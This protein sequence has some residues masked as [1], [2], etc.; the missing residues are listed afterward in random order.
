MEPYTLNRSFLRNNVIDKFK[1]IIWT[2]RYYGDSAVEM[3]VP[4]TTDMFQKLA[5]GTFLAID[6][7]DEVMILE[8]MS[9]EKGELKVSGISILPWLDNRFVRTSANHEDQH[10]P[11]EFATAGGAVAAIIWYM[12]CDG[13]PYLDGTL[14]M[15]ISNPQQFK[16]PGLV[17]IQD[18]KSGGPVKLAIPYGPV[19]KAAREVATT[20][21][22]G[23][24]ITL[25]RADDQGYLLGLRTYKGLDRTSNQDINPVVRFS[26]QM[27]SFTDIKELQSIAALKTVVYTFATGLKPNEGE[28][29]IT[30]T[31]GVATLSGQYTGFDL[32]A[33]QVFPGDITTDLVGGDPAKVVDILNS[34]ALDELTGHHFI[35]SVDGEIVPDSQFKYGAHYNLGDLIEV[36][37]NTGVTQAARITEYI[38]SHDSAGEK[39]YPTVTMIG[40]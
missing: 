30:T 7:S 2:E 17:W 35:K 6:K 5:P 37:G 27:D 31:P 20:Y 11:L 3:V 40:S 18:D 13:S 19:Y 4:A 36:E 21:E 23:M 8:S 26:P 39:E 29:T 33:L 1:S 10:F 32:R 34:R 25:D 24:T 38:R 14:P 12:C 28:P 22:I 16:I 9:I 15:G